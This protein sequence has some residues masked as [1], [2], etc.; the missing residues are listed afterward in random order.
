M[1]EHQYNKIIAALKKTAEENLKKNGANEGIQSSERTGMNPNQK[2]WKETLDE[3]NKKKEEVNSME[4]RVLEL[5]LKSEK[6]ALDHKIAMQ[7]KDD[8]ISEERLRYKH[9]ESDLRQAMA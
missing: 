3:L 4:A 5:E 7:A 9:K 8:E 2:E 6:V 1:R